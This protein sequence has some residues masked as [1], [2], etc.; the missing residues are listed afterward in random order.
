MTQHM[1]AFVQPRNKDI[2]AESRRYSRVVCQ[3][4][5]ISFVEVK[6]LFFFK[7]E[8]RHI[9]KLKPWG[10]YD[11]LVE[12]YEWDTEIAQAF[13]D[14]L[15][16]MLTFD[17][18]ERATA[19]ECLVHPFLQDVWPANEAPFLGSLVSGNEL[20][21][22]DQEDLEEDLDYDVNEDEMENNLLAMSNS[23]QILDNNQDVGIVN[24]DP[25][26]NGD[27][28]GSTGLFTAM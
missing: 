16:P 5:I 4:V 8:L 23:L 18:A 10:L 12:K 24:E 14:W 1:S 20:E 17:T 15:V 9:T 2:S 6:R 13:A 25:D 21:Q 22:A 19:E 7:G 26:D 11:V 28:F 27:C 3:I